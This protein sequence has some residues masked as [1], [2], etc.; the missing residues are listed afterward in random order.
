MANARGRTRLERTFAKALWGRGLRYLTDAGY[1][2]R[3]GRSLP[4]HPDLIFPRKRVVIFVDG[5]FWHGCLQCGGIPQHSGELWRRKIE[6]NVERDSR[7]VTEL[8]AG[9]WAVIR[10]PGHDLKTK[11]LMEQTAGTIADQIRE[12]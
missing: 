5:C 10:V 12:Y 3:Y 2:A 6:N 11:A 7:V 9:G 1:K 4:G 8:R